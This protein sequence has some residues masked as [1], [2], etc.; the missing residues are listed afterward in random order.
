MRSI[1]CGLSFLAAR[2]HVG[3]ALGR[4]QSIPHVIP[5]RKDQK[6]ERREQLLQLADEFGIEYTTT[7]QV[8]HTTEGSLLQNLLARREVRA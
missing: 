8:D 1:L 5:E 3:A 2:R 6:K 4:R 7:F